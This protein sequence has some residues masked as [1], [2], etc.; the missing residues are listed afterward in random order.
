MSEPGK[1][2]WDGVYWDAVN[3]YIDKVGKE[4]NEEW[5]KRGSNPPLFR[6]FDEFQLDYDEY[7]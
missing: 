1:C 3:R 4:I 7:I 2:W 5:K 6:P